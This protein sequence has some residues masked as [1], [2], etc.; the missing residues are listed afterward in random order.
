MH[1]VRGS[2]PR[3]SRPLYL[4]RNLLYTLT[5]SMETIYAT[6]ACALRATG[7]ATA[8]TAGPAEPEVKELGAVPGECS[9]KSRVDR[10]L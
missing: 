8:R 2:P 10:G 4:P 5:R 9:G 1:S 6:A 3:P 7:T